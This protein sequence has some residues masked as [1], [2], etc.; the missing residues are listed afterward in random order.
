MYWDNGTGRGL[1][2]LHRDGLAP[3]D[4]LPARRADLRRQ[5]DLDAGAEPERHRRHRG[6][7]LPDPGLDSGNVTKTETIPANSRKHLQHGRALR[8]HRAGRHHGHMQDLRQE[9]HGRARHVLELT[10]VRART[11]SGVLG[12][13]SL[14]TSG[15]QRF[16]RGPRPRGAIAPLEERA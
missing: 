8:H 13:A 15:V 5:G 6:H 7:H 4:L 14:I 1:P 16:R 9:D 3:H 2:R 11:P 12:L 10:E